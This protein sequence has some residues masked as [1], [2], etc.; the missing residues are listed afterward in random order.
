MDQDR[1]YQP[2]DSKDAMRFVEKLFNKYKDA[3]LTDELLAY[4]Q[5]LIYYVKTSVIETAKAENQ[6]QRV[7]NAQNM[8]EVMQ[9]WIRIRALGQPFTG[10]LRQFKYQRNQHTH[11]KQGS[12]KM[13]NHRGSV[14][15][16][17]R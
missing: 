14:R 11:Y 12:G 17:M 5:K 10:T 2:T 13:K 9:D 7:K 6:P 16:S 3:P 1:Y 4:H 15:R 8:L